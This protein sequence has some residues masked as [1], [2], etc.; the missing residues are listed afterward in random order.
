MDAEGQALGGAGYTR[1]RGLWGGSSTA[2]ATAGGG[3]GFF[4]R[5]SEG[6]PFFAQENAF[7]GTLAVININPEIKMRS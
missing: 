3:G 5:S 6:V 7:L 1:R 4:G 2:D